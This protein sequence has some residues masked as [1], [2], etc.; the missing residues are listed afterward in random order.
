M[1]R[2]IVIDDDPAVLES[3]AF[4][5]DVWGC[6]VTAYRSAFDFLNAGPGEGDCLL[7]DQHMP[8]MSGLELVTRLRE[9]GL[10]F[11]TLLITGAPS[12]SIE[13]SAAAFG[14]ALQPKPLD[15]AAL[16]AFLRQNCR[17]GP[18]IP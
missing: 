2:V 10:E 11:P 18:D 1:C 4:L 16:I 9:L 6:Q 12:P 8:E 14:I 17:L 5:L 15:E 13:A 3:T 7:L